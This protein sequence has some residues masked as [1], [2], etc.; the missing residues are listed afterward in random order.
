[1]GLELK[2]KEKQMAVQLIKGIT[3][4]CG[5]MAIIQKLQNFGIMQ[6]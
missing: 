4:Y 2:K 1:M 3:C 6:R 5:S